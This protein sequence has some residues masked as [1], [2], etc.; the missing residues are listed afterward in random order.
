MKN[1]AHYDH[2]LDLSTPIADWILLVLMALVAGG[3]ICCLILI[4]YGGWR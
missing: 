2:D 1:H 3:L 4:S